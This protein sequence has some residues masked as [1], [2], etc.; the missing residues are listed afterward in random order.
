MAKHNNSRIRHRDFQVRD[1]VLR[2]VTDATREARNQLGRTLHNHF[3]ANERHLPP[4]D[5][6]QAEVVPPME[7]GAPEKILLVD[8]G[9]KNNTPHF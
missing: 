3:M 6:R 2:K 4:R 5:A 7:H 8:D 1:L 9:T